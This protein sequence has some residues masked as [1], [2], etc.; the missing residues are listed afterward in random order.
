MSQTREKQILWKKQ[1][2]RTD[3]EKETK[4]PIN[5]GGGGKCE[6][7]SMLPRA[8]AMRQER[9][10]AAWNISKARSNHYTA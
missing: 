5:G 3:R 6:H 9:S 8:E 2:V 4:N 1:A 10:K 7:G